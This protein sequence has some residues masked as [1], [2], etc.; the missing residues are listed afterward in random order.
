M[1]TELKKFVRH[2]TASLDEIS[3]NLHRSRQLAVASHAP[4]RRIRR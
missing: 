3:V 1:L 4:V 2:L